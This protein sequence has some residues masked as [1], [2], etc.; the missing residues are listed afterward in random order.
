MRIQENWEEF[1][2]IRTI[3]YEFG[4]FSGLHEWTPICDCFFQNIF[5]IRTVI[6]SNLSEFLSILLNSHHEFVRNRAISGDFARICDLVAALYFHKN[7][8]NVF[9]FY[10][11]LKS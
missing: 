11:I 8:N 5:I 10:K 6:L 1:E 3:S 4:N 7:E 2:R 9:G